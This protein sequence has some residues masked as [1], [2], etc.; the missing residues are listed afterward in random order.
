MKVAVRK[1]GFRAFVFAQRKAD[2][3]SIF[4]IQMTALN[5]LIRNKL[6]PLDVVLAVHRMRSGS[7]FNENLVVIDGDHRNMLF[8]SAV[9]H[10]RDEQL[11]FLAAADWN[12]ARI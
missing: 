12:R 3:G 6:D 5:A 4:R 1:N 7:N 11:H 8:N 2:G 9:G 10:S